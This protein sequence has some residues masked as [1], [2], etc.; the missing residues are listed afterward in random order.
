MTKG[1]NLKNPSAAIL[2]GDGAQATYINHETDYKEKV[3]KFKFIPTEQMREKYSD[4]D[5]DKEFNTTFWGIPCIEKQ[6]PMEMCEQWDGS[7]MTQTWVFK[8]DY[9]GADCGRDTHETE[10]W[11][12]KYKHQ[13]S[14]NN[15]L[16]SQLRQLRLSTRKAMRHPNAIEL[17]YIERFKRYNEAALAGSQKEKDKGDS[18]D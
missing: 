1:S 16:K 3:Y 8:C 13:L 11:K 10:E 12:S 5:F 18:D 17:S 9:Y 4:I 2:F 7:V 15:I 14:L 6:Y